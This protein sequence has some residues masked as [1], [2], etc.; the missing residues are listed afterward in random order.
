[1]QQRASL[2]DMAKRGTNMLFDRGVGIWH[3]AARDASLELAQ[4]YSIFGSIPF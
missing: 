1:M 4:P 2:L 3:I